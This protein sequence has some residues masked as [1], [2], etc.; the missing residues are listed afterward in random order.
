M[1]GHRYRDTAFYFKGI[2]SVNFPNALINIGR[3]AF[4]SNYLTDVTIPNGVTTIGTNAFSNNQLTRVVFP[5]S[6][7]TIGEYAF[8]NN[9]D[10]AEV[11]IPNGDTALGEGVFSG[12][13]P[14]LIIY[15]VPGSSANDYAIN[16]SI[17]FV[18]YTE[19]PTTISFQGSSMNSS[20]SVLT[21]NFSETWLTI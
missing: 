21:L 13:S 10:L 2:K 18:A 8:A 17:T 14:D 9:N 7:T 20:N 6:V 12:C 15:G 5:N 11:V 4:G 19:V 16:H 1:F 3:Y